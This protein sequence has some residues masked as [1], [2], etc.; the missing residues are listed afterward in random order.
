MMD[1]YNV[2][3]LAAI[4]YQFGHACIIE[5]P[6]MPG[7]ARAALPYHIFGRGCNDAGTAEG[8]YE[9]V[10]GHVGVLES[11]THATTLHQ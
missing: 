5:V 7:T 8:T 1:R 4:H 2:S 6:H 11:K 10:F 3:T 9:T